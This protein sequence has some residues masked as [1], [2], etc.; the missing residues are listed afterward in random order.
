[1]SENEQPVAEPADPFT[2]LA[3]GFI[4]V[5]EVFKNYMAAGFTEDQAL[6]LIAYMGQRPTADENPGTP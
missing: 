3:Q 5:H 6:R 4:T 2:E 1:M